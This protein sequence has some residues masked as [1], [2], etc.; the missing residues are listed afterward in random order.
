MKIGTD[1][2]TSSPRAS[3][4][5]AILFGIGAALTLDEFALWLRLE[6]VYSA[7]KGRESI[8]AVVLFGAIWAMVHAWYF[9]SGR[10]RTN[11]AS[12]LNLAP[13][14][15]SYSTSAARAGARGCHSLITRP[16]W[17]LSS[18][19]ISPVKPG[20]SI[21]PVMSSSSHL[22]SAALSGADPTKFNNP[23]SYNPSEGM[24]L[25][26]GQQNKSHLQTRSLQ[27]GV[28]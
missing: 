24:K 25:L 11:F 23:S 18:P 14:K 19:G 3:R 9:L 27:C 6:D 20:G 13:V 2:T 4:I 1:A 21:S 26:S 5:T 8:H 17:P 7:R 15:W 10:H 16:N 28:V 12:C 22:P